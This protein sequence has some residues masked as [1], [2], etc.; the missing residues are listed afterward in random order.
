MLRTIVLAL[1]CVLVAAPPVMAKKRHGH[2]AKKVKR[3]KR[4]VRMQRAAPTRV[5]AVEQHP[6]PELIKRSIN[7]E[8]PPPA[9]ASPAA[10]PDPV[11]APSPPVAHGPMGPQDS[12][13]EVPGSRMKKR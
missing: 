8:T 10:A 12:D 11:A 5:A 1:A 9:A 4:L 3:G 13:D 7:S 6:A 2:A